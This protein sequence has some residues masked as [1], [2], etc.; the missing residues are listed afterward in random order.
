MT[1]EA[2]WEVIDKQASLRLASGF[3]SHYDN[4]TKKKNIYIYIHRHVHII[5]FGSTLHMV[6]GTNMKSDFTF[7]PRYPCMKMKTGELNYKLRQP[8]PE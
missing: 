2:G 5:R 7:P 6:G 1:M 8:D 4:N 3:P